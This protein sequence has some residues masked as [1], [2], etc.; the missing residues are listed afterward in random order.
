MS[1][2]SPFLLIIILGFVSLLGDI[3]YEGA[4]SIIGPYF[5]TLG[6]SATVVGFVAGAGEFIGYG[7][8]LISGYLTDKLKKYWLITIIGYIINLFAI[9]ALAL[10]KTWPQSAILVITERIGKALRTPARDTI[11]SY[12]TSKIGRGK[13]FG[14]HEAMDQ[15]GAMLGPLLIT[16]ILSSTGSYKIS[17]GILGIPALL[18]FLILLIARFLYP[19]PQK[20]ETKAL[21]LTKKTF[22]K[23]FWI[24]ILA[25]GLYGAGYADFALIAYHLKKTEVLKQQWIPLFYAIAMGIDAISALF[26]GYLFDKKGFSVLI[27]AVLISLF[28]SPFV[29]LGKFFLVLFGMILWGIGMGAQESIM[30]AAI[31]FFIP[32]DKRATGYG[33][34]NAFYGFLWFLGSIILGVLYDTSLISLIIVSML[35]Q[36]SSIPL[37]LIL[38]K[39]ELKRS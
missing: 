18:A 32:K 33:I 24:Y 19:N 1:Y 11:L 26:F 21:T 35:L 37:L 3:T 6:A 10:T 23:K 15:I 4:R 9:P 12:A 17:F 27:L 38:S 29:F 5:A 34:F 8:R 14:F 31:S 36:L 13:G 28:S 25:I 22:S 2:R 16:F 7:L 39:P 30:R 20:L